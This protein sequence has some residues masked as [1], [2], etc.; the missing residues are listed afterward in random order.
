MPA[1]ASA[2]ASRRRIGFLLIRSQRGLP[3]RFFRR[4]LLAVDPHVLAHVLR[5]IEL[6]RVAEQLDERIAE[7]G[8][9]GRAGDGGARVERQSVG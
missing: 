8:G 9:I 7:A 1:G 6:L 3:F 2:E 5:E 4:Q